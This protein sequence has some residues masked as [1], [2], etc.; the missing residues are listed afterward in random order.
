MPGRL[1]LRRTI[2]SPAY[3]RRFFFDVDAVSRSFQPCAQFPAAEQFEPAM[4]AGSGSAN[5]DTVVI[6]DSAAGR[7]A[8][9]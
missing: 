4:S 5:D 1:P 8:A 9:G 2:I 6:Y 3:S 7:R